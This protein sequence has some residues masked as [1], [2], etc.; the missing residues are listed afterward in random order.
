MKVITIGKREFI[1]Q[2][3]KYLKM[4]EKEGDIVITHQ[5]KPKLHLSPIKKKSIKDLQ[6]LIKA[7]KS[8][9]DIN[10]PVFPEYTQW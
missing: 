10:D 8:K 7:V 5:K 9:D 6:G 3:S 2:T 4:A 1:Q